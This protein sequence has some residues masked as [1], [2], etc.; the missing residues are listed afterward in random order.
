MRAKSDVLALARRE[1][2]RRPRP[3]GSGAKRAPGGRVRM[4]GD[5]RRAAILRQAA[6]FF[7]EYGLTAQTRALADAC[8]VSQRLLYRFFPSKSALIEEVYRAEIVAPFEVAWFAELSDRSR[9]V[10]DRLIDFY[11][12][13]YR[14]VLTRRWLRLFLY[15]SLA[16]YEM[17]PGYIS[18]VIVR[19]LELIVD[20][21]ASELGLVLPRDRARVLEIGWTLHGS[22]SHLAIRREIYGSRTEEAAEKAIADQVRIFVAGVPKVLA[23]AAARSARPA[24]RAAAAR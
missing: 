19:L 22:V 1:A 15:A 12:D 10:T 5:E 2:P 8:G 23:T 14:R 7:A 4:S 16:D 3:A 21:V 24:A 17:A 9:P 13:Y 11:T 20:E 18:A 6:A